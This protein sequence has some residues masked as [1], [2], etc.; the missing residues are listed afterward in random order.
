MAERRAVGAILRDAS[1]TLQ[2]V[3]RDELLRYFYKRRSEI[4]KEGSV[5]HPSGGVT[6]PSP[7]NGLG[8]TGKTARDHT[9]T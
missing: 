5:G 3:R 7:R 4:L 6:P 9:L 8:K 1:E 2:T